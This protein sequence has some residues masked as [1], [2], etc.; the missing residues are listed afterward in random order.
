M[1][2]RQKEPGPLPRLPKGL[3]TMTG[4]VRPCRFPRSMVSTFL[5][6]RHFLHL[7]PLEA[8]FS[9]PGPCMVHIVNFLE[10]EFLS[11]L[12]TAT[13]CE[14]FMRPACGRF[15]SLAAWRFLMRKRLASPNLSARVEL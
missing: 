3:R 4:C 8:T 6:P 7:R 12:F 15:M 1:E 11:G 2:G 14:G 9:T 5:G 13:G 10:K